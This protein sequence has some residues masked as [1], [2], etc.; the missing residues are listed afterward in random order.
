MSALVRHVGHPFEQMYAS[1]PPWKG[2]K[3]CG[4]PMPFLN[5]LE[6]RRF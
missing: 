6:L 3:D 1:E 4:S 5:K 2:S